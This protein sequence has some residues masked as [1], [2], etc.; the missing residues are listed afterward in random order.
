MVHGERDPIVPFH[1]S[2][3]LERAVRSRLTRLDLPA[4]GHHD[5]FVKGGKQLW[6]QVYDFID[7]V[8]DGNTKST[9]NAGAQDIAVQS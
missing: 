2:Q 5:L 9:T 1:M 8:S 6:N 7:S 4:V 3:T